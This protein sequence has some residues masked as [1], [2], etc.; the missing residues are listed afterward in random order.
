M[1]I[2]TSDMEKVVG[3]LSKALP[4]IVFDH[5]PCALDVAE[6]IGLGGP[7]CINGHLKRGPSE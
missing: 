4:Q 2:M 1:N 3:M 7:A 6:L 5:Q